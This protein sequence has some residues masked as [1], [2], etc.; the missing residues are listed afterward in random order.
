MIYSLIIHTT[1]IYKASKEI[2]QLNMFRKSFTEKVRFEPGL[3]NEKGGRR[4][5]ILERSKKIM[6]VQK[7]KK[8]SF[9]MKMRRILD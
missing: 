3:A 5:G 8:R 1:F 7:A 9:P 4:R 6:A 2:N